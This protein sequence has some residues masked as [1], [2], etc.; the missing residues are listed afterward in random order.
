MNFERL[1][2]SNNAEEWRVALENYW[3]G[4]KQPNKELE[5][6]MA[7]LD[8]VS[9]ARM[10][11]DEF[12]DFL[13]SKYFAWKYTAPN[14]LATTRKS[15]QQYLD[16]GNL[17]ELQDIKDKLFSFD[18]KD[19]RKGLSIAYSIRGL[20]SAGASGL[21]AVLFPEDFGT[22]DQFV[23]KNLQKIEDLPEREVIA[24][25]SPEGITLS[26]AEV[27]ISILKRK[28][29]LL[30][31]VNRTDFWTPRKVDMVLWVLRDDE[32]D[33]FLGP[34]EVKRLSGAERF[35]SS[36]N[37]LDKNILDF[38]SWAFSG[39]S[40]NAIR[41]TLAEFI[42][43]VALGVDAGNVREEWQPYD[44]ITEEG[45]KVE[46]KSSSYLQSWDQ[47]RL[48]KPMFSCGRKNLD[49]TLEQDGKKIRRA[50]VYVFAL[51]AEKDKLRLDP[52]NLDQWEFIV[53]STQ[54]LDTKL[55][56]Q[57]TLSIES[58]R[59]IDCPTVSFSGLN[60]AIHKAYNEGLG[61]CWANKA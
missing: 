49:N 16:D 44:L 30:N 8:A 2:N 18:R 51:L 54:K 22:V 28:A 12:Y 29:T 17:S 57:K 34:I 60:R 42:V 9:I 25:I 59:L 21:L 31:E 38:W 50:D 48:S 4:V 20:G 43:A 36:G 19:I 26:Q 55:G 58:L 37:E 6:W 11:V 13:Y 33:R 15:L 3:S 39:I 61:N 1:W 53:V 41:G 7:E 40:I 10:N 46:V 35:I 56:D 5:K 32:N 47:K 52:L 23:V 14:R 27:L 45:I 24:R